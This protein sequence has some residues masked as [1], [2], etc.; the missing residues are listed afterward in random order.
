M[1]RFA[2]FSIITLACVGLASA[3]D[4]SPTTKGKIQIGDHR[5]KMDVSKIYEIKV[6]GEGFIPIVQIRPG[7]FVQVK[8]DRDNDLYSAYFMPQESRE[9]RI[10][11]I[12][13]TY[14][15]LGM[16]PF[17]YSITVKP[18]T[19]AEKPVL[20]EKSK[21]SADDPIY[22]VEGGAQLPF[23]A[24]P[25]KM[26]GKQLYIIDMVG[27]SAMSQFE[28]NMILE[29]PDGNIVARDES[30]SPRSARIFFQPRRDGDYR[31]IASSYGKATGDFMLTVRSQA[32]DKE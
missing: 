11:I 23:K 22:K 28:P 4:Q 7:R 27:T 14:E 10:V 24:F 30:G 20:A 18:I 19:L 12:P 25:I 17:E 5:Y 13:D 26:K 8:V 9:H 6:Q 15:D 29:G 3:Q 32:K 1:T 31:I 2:A 16:N 21:I